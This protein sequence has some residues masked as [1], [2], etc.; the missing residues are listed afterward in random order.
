[1][2]EFRVFPCPSA[3]TY[4]GRLVT[5]GLKERIIL[6]ALVCAKDF[7]VHAPVLVERVWHGEPMYAPADTLRTHIY[8]IRRAIAGVAGQGTGRGLVKTVHVRGGA[9]Y[10]LAM[11]AVNVDVRRWELD[12]EVAREKLM[13]EPG[14]ETEAGL[15]TVLSVWSGAP[16]GDAG[17]WEFAR[18]E[19]QRL[20]DL[21]RDGL[22]EL[23]DFRVGMRRHREV[24]ADLTSLTEDYPGD[25]GIWERLIVALWR[26]RQDQAAAQACRD[27]TMVLNGLG[28]DTSEVRQLH[29]SVLRGEMPR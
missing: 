3:L 28:L 17:E 13:W 26:G 23:I 22:V 18:N 16:F 11:S 20:A 24:V 5:L 7:T 29:E 6:L 15:A 8:H 1:M 2:F 19:R 12:L 25:F 14:R 4:D 27:C 21:R 10:S 9:A